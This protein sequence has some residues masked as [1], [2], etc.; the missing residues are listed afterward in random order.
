MQRIARLQT[1]KYWKNTE[2]NLSMFDKTLKNKIRSAHRKR[3]CK[4]A[5]VHCGSFDEFHQISRVYP[6]FILTEKNTK[7]FSRILHFVN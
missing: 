1:L 7:E 4:Q 3:V 5:F 6:A 2:K